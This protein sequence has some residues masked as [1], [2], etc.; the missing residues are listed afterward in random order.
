MN[1]ERIGLLL[2]GQTPRPDLTAPLDHL[3][4]AYDLL[5][6]GALDALSESDLPTSDKG[7]YPLVTRL[8]DGRIVT[9]DEQYLTPLLQAT[10]NTLEQEAAM[11]ILLLCAG[12]FP[13]LQSTRPLIRPFQLAARSLTTMGLSH[14]SVIVP[15]D[16]QVAPSVRKWT[17]AGFCPTILSIESKRTNQSLED[18][19][20]A[21]HSESDLGEAL[22]LD[23]VGHPRDAIAR[24]QAAVDIPVVD[25]GHLAVATLEAM[26]SQT[27][28]PGKSISEA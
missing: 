8:R 27:P 3:A 26:L 1:R 15:T 11:A 10:I 6:R 14:I 12:P 17:D 20:S 22:V 16:D 24:V 21:H 19:I 25:L 7:T 13:V 4:G 2:I 5:V 28:P 23:Y 18:W 9:V